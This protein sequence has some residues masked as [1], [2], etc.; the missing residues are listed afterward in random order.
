MSYEHEG[1]VIHDHMV[2]ALTEY[3]D[4]GRPLGNFLN[5]IVSNDFSDAVCRADSVNLAN[6]K[7]YAIWL[8]NQCPRKA[9]GSPAAVSKWIEIGGLNG[10][11][12]ERRRRR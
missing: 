2:E 10:I 5:A 7:A 4:N 8:N 9:W 12:A 6:L 3:V 1:F 11:E